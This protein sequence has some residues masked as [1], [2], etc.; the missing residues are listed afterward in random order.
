MRPR[1]PQL[2]RKRAFIGSAIAVGLVA[3]LTGG[4]TPTGIW[5]D[6]SPTG[7][8]A[9]PGWVHMHLDGAIFNL[10]FQGV[11]FYGGETG[12]YTGRTIENELNLSPYGG[13]M[14]RSLKPTDSVWRSE[15]ASGN[16]YITKKFAAHTYNTSDPTWASKLLMQWKADRPYDALFLAYRIKAKSGFDF[17]LGGKLPGL[18]GGSCP[19]GGQAVSESEEPGGP[20]HAVGWSARSMWRRDGEL[21]QYVYAPSLDGEWGSEFWYLSEHGRRVSLADNK[22]HTIEHFVQMDSYKQERNPVTGK[23]SVKHYYGRIV[24]WVD[25]AEVLRVGGIRFRDDDS[26]GIDQLK[27]STYMGGNSSYWAPKVDSFLQFDDVVVST[28]RITG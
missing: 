12:Y 2:G 20:S 7:S 22:W 5:D 21:Q 16:K 25:G 11:N 10:S 8:S 27:I 26:F 18:C 14:G 23:V 1:P 19:V 4:S 13:Y 28:K 9:D 3:T 6:G 15:D 17:R 24:A